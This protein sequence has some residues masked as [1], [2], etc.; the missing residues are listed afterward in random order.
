MSVPVTEIAIP[1][2][3]LFHAS[4]R[5][6]SH[7]G[8][9]KQALQARARR[10]A[11]GLEADLEQGLANA[12]PDDRGVVTDVVIVKATG[13][14][15]NMLTAMMLIMPG[16]EQVE[17]TQI[18]KSFNDLWTVLC[19]SSPVL[20]DIHFEAMVPEG[21]GYVMCM[22]VSKCFS[23][24]GQKNAGG[25]SGAV[26]LMELLNALKGNLK[27]AVMHNQDEDKTKH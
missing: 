9:V 5:D 22:M 2:F 15:E 27:A 20:G 12:A 13:H 19:G 26:E 17:S 14:S 11:R 16:K 6:A 7:E 18:A 10:E 21:V 3:V 4:L 1:Q 24:Y 8:E 23:E 25:N